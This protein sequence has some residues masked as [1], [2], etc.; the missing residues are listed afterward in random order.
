M[1]IE[2]YMDPILL[3]S[4]LGIYTHAC[5]RF[6]LFVLITAVVYV[7]KDNTCGFWKEIEEKKKKERLRHPV[8]M[9]KCVC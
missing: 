6:C 7:L 9:Y 3:Q 4:T 1:F 5:L 2:F 8:L